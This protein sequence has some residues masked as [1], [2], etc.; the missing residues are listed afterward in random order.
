MAFGSSRRVLRPAAL[1][2]VLPSLLDAGAA[3]MPRQTTNQRRHSTAT[4]AGLEADLAAA[5]W[6]A[7]STTTRDREIERRGASTTIVRRHQRRGE[8][9][10][11]T[12]AGA[13]PSSP[14]PIALPLAASCFISQSAIRGVAPQPAADGHA[15]TREQI[16]GMVERLAAR[17]KRVPRT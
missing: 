16:R 14:S 1:A 15:I 10:A 4:S 3:R 7:S 8:R 13:E 9:A 2:F 17:M 11:A 6:A 12:N 5:R